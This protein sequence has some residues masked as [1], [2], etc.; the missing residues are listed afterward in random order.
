MSTEP[1]LTRKRL[2]SSGGARWKRSETGFGASPLLARALFSQPYIL[3]ALAT[4]CWSGNHILG[5]AIAGHVP[6][7]GASM[8]RWG[9]GALLLLPFAQS[10]MRRDWSLIARNKIMI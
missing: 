10:R 3:L 8:V 2:R 5:R 1:E 9:I 7:L 4:L 6:P